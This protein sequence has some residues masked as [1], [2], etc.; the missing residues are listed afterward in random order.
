MFHS[1]TFCDMCLSSIRPTLIRD[2]PRAVVTHIQNELCLVCLTTSMYLVC[3]GDEVTQPN[4][5]ITPRCG[6]CERDLS[7]ELDAYYG[8]DK[9]MHDFCVKCRREV[10]NK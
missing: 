4:I 3:E 5:R 6:K 9:R 7:R 10:F 1:T 8:R 2:Y